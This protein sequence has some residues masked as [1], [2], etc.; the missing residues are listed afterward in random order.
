MTGISCLLMIFW[1]FWGC[2]QTVQPL[3]PVL[4]ITEWVCD[5]EADKQVK[6]GDLDAGIERH[7]SFL[8]NHPANGLAL[9]HL[10]YAYGRQGHFELEAEFY[11]KAI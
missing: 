9:Y 7:I 8:Q 10:G 6:A 2:A 5:P 3:K 1:C 4:A 11:E